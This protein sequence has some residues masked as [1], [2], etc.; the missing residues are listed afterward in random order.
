MSTTSQ[1]QAAGKTVLCTWEVGGE[2]GHIS[3]LAA[4]TCR[5]EQAGYRVVVALKDLSRAQPFFAETRAT[6]LQ[7]PVWLPKITMQRPIACMADAMLL[8]GYLE[9]DPLDCLVR[10]WEALVDLV[11]PDLVIFDYSPTAMLAMQGLAVPKIVT[12]TGF[13]DP[14]PGLPTVDWRPYT[15]NDNLVQRQ[16]QRV[17]A[18]INA[19]L[20][21]RRAEPLDCLADLFRTNR[22]LITNLRELDIYPARSDAWYCLAPSP[23]N[24][25]RVAFAE[26]GRP[27]LIAYLKPSYPRFEWLVKTLASCAADVFIA[28][29]RGPIEQL[30]TWA[31]GRVRFST[32]L[33]D[34]PGALKDADLFVGHGNAGSVRESLV[35]GTPVVVLPIQLEQLLTGQRVQRLGVGKLVEQVPT[36]DALGEAI[37]EA[38]ADLPRCRSAIEAVLRDYPRP[39]LSVQEAALRACDELLRPARPAGDE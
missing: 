34:L 10:A 8:L 16:E 3:R 20:A 11:R 7:A 4:I 2:L 26:D 23:S 30:Q 24:G 22:V 18:N 38:L 5:L 36:E 35:L 14:V 28:C 39:H 31:K 29:P 27:R 17:L 37:A 19:V 13:C 12:G 25:S 32:E 9:P 33:V 1:R 15:A 6:L 21:R